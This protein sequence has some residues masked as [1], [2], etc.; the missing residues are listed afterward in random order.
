MVYTLLNTQR[1]AVASRA[2]IFQFS[3]CD[4]YHLLCKISLICYSYWLGMDV[5]I[6]INSLRSCNTTWRHRTIAT[7][8]HIIDCNIFGAKP[9][10]KPLHETNACLLTR[11]NNL[12]FTRRNK[13]FL[14]FFWNTINAIQDTAIYTVVFKIICDCFC[15]SLFLS[16]PIMYFANYVYLQR[17]RKLT[18]FPKDLSRLLILSGDYLSVPR[19]SCQRGPSPR[20]R[21]TVFTKT[22]LTARHVQTKIH[23]YATSFNSR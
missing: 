12:Q 23:V 2:T 11:R 9:S 17:E 4:C 8:V 19:I 7:L 15:P 16:K 10:H 5:M 22:E 14:Y 3:V 1:I 21:L 20:F 13:S 6:G 18:L